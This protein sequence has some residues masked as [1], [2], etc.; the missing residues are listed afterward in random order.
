MAVATSIEEVVKRLVFDG[1]SVRAKTVDAAGN[2]SHGTYG[3]K[4]IFCGTFCVAKPQ[5]KR[6]TNCRAHEVRG[7]GAPC[8]VYTA[9]L[10]DAIAFL[11]SSNFRTLFNF[12]NFSS[13]IISIPTFIAGNAAKH[14]SSLNSC[15]PLLNIE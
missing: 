1:W 13:K 15:I 9:P 10:R 3:C 8:Y 4:L 6:L 2:Q 14:S 5:K 11:A 7:A 12:S